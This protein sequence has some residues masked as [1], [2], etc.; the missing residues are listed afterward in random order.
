MI[1]R[2]AQRSLQVL[3]SEFPA[4]AL[5]GPRQ[6]GKTTLAQSIAKGQ[7]KDVLYLDLERASDQRKLYDPEIFF[8][9]NRDKLI[10]LD[11]V[12]SMP[13]LF[14]ALRPEIDTLRK[15]G[16]FLL[17]GSA[18][19][20][21]VKGV[22]ESLA[23]RIAY[24]ELT[25]INLTE[26]RAAHYGMARH[27]FRGGYPTA[28]TVKADK[29]YLRWAENFVRSYIE[30]DLSALFGVNLSPVII[31][32]FWEMLAAN[33][34]GIL[35]IE[36]YARSLGISGP[37]VARYLE[38]MEGAY[39]VRLLQPW[40]ANVN[41]RLVKSPKVYVRDTGIIHLLNH[42][43]SADRL[44]GNIIVGSSWESYVVEEVIRHLPAAV[45]AYYYR[46]QHGAE[47]DLVLVKGVKP[48]ACIE[49]KFSKAPV[50]SAGFYQ[51][52][53]DLKTKQNWLV[54]AGRDEYKNKE[55]ITFTSLELF[56]TKHLRKL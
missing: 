32:N 9:A 16:R 11:E 17:T 56:L 28:L 30:R 55:R 43:A 52:V 14:A 15:P 35:N 36:N 13:H 23:G 1:K 26:A 27:W 50:P 25:P 34:G 2:E 3:L 5:L 38:F 33:T 53:E 54:Y 29:A 40:F 6:V 10:I 46:T 51:C 45:T 22:S 8:E 7:K 39:L 18:S 37:T 20:Q 4:V 19:P 12:Q 44:P 48:I 47:A 24:Q 21:L 41:K 31:R 42:I 49:I